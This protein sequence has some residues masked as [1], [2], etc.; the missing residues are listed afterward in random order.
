MPDYPFEDCRIFLTRRCNLN[1]SFCKISRGI[2][3]ELSVEEWKAAF[4]NLEAIG[5]KRVKLLGGEPTAFEGLEQLIR[6]ANRKTNI[7]LSIESNST[8]SAEMFDS[9]VASGL[10]GYCTDVN[11]LNTDSRLGKPNVGLKMLEKFKE[12]ST[13]HLE[14][15]VVVNKSNLYEL[16]ELANSLSEKK[17]QINLIPIHYGAQYPYWEFRSNDIA[18]KLKFTEKDQKDI[19]RIFMKIIQIKKEHGMVQNSESYLSNFAEH[20]IRL[21]WHCSKPV[22]F[23]IDSDGSFRICNDIHGEVAKYNVLSIN[24]LMLEKFKEDW[25]KSKIRIGCP[26]CYYSPFYEA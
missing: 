4:K 20:A 25:M 6:F 10:K 23:R 15:N 22:Q 18:A 24:K 11:S 12:N 13:K 2:I 1:C 5:A 7:E 8:F 16:P 26:G 19:E 14:A 3:K 9:L 17:I 21:D